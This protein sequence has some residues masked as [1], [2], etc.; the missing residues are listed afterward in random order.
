[1]GLR[2]ARPFWK[3]LVLIQPYGRTF[4]MHFLSIFSHS[5]FRWTGCRFYVLGNHHL[6][7]FPNYFPKNCSLRWGSFSIILSNFLDLKHNRW[8]PFLGVVRRHFG[9]CSFF[10]CLDFCAN[11]LHCF[12]KEYCFDGSLFECESFW[13]KL[14]GTTNPRLKLLWN[15][16]MMAF[17]FCGRPSQAF[18][19][20][21]FFLVLVFYSGKDLQGSFPRSTRGFKLT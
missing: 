1:M 8:C 11:F 5:F 16:V 20:F 13:I 12:E 7:Q 14:I 10:L 3:F 21:S 9:F 18:F 17:C 19:T 6:T 15:I 4:P 2:H